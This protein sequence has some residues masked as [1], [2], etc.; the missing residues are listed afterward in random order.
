ATV[1]IH[2]RSGDVEVSQ[3]AEARIKN[4]NGDISLSNV[5]RAVEAGTIGGDLSLMNSQGRVRL[6]TVGGD[7]DAVNVMTME[8]GDDFSATSISG[9][10]DLENVAHTRLSANTTS[11]MITVSGKLAPRGSYDLNTISGD[12]EMNIPQDSAFQISARAP[13]GSITTDFAIKSDSDRDAA[14]LLEQGSLT[15]TYG[16]SDWA[17][18]TIHSFSG[19]VRLLKR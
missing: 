16:K 9:D 8:E 14:N 1:Q 15:G 6:T 13:Q 5:T 12:V 4:T 18:I 3:V 17:S 7:I 2:L 10:I 19:A 11:G